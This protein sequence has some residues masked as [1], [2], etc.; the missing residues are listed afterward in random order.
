M[1]NKVIVTYSGVL[2]DVEMQSFKDEIEKEVGFELTLD[3]R[4]PA[5]TNFIGFDTIVDLFFEYDIHK[6]IAWRA[7]EVT[8]AKLWQLARGKKMTTVS[9]KNHLPV[10]TEISKHYIRIPITFGR[11][12]TQHFY[13]SNKLSEDVV[14]KGMSI[15]LTASKKRKRKKDNLLI[16]PP[17]VDEYIRLKKNGKWK[18]IKDQKKYREKMRA[19]LKKKNKL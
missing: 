18:M 5:V 14:Q 12:Y 1:E 13:I 15:L 7:I 6:A 2:S 9:S 19:K 8:V 17:Y 3:K 11:T 10:V 16:Q 4:K